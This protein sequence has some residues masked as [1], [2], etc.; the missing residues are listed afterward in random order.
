MADNDHGHDGGALSYELII[1]PNS[2]KHV[3]P[4][5]ALLSN[6]HNGASSSSRRFSSKEL[7]KGRLIAFCNLN[8]DGGGGDGQSQQ[9]W[10]S[11]SSMRKERNGGELT[12]PSTGTGDSSSMLTWTLSQKEL[13]QRK[14]KHPKIKVS[15]FLVIN[16]ASS[17]SSSNVNGIDSV[18]FENDDNDEHHA[19]KSDEVQT[20]ATSTNFW[21]RRTMEHVGWIAMDVRDIPVVHSGEAEAGEGNLDYL[22]CLSH[23]KRSIFKVSGAALGAEVTVSSCL[24][25]Y[26]YGIGSNNS[27]EEAQHATGTPLARRQGLEQEVTI[28]NN[29][30]RNAALHQSLALGASI[31]NDTTNFSSIYD[32]QEIKPVRGGSGSIELLENG[33]NEP[34]FNDQNLNLNYEITDKAIGIIGTGN[35]NRLMVNNTGPN[36]TSMTLPTN[37]RRPLGEL[38]ASPQHQPD[39]WVVDSENITYSSFPEEGCSDPHNSSS[40]RM[41]HNGDGEN[42]IQHQRQD[43]KENEADEWHTWKANQERIWYDKLRTKEDQMIVALTTQQQ[44]KDKERDSFLKAA[45]LEYRHLEETLQQA[46]V[47]VERN[48]QEVQA[49][50]Q[51]LHHEFTHL[52]K[53]LEDKSRLIQQQAQVAVEAERLKGAVTETRAKVAEERVQQLGTELSSLR[54]VQQREETNTRTAAA[55]SAAS[56]DVLL[57]TQKE[58]LEHEQKMEQNKLFEAMKAKLAKGASEHKRHQEHAA[59][60]ERLINIERQKV[61][62]LQARNGEESK[63]QNIIT[64]DVPAM[65]DNTEQEQEEITQLREEFQALELQMSS[66]NLQVPIVD[67]HDSF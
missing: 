35:V 19:Q 1:H 17:S 61:Q 51:Q 28:S 20:T 30:T 62:A 47:D 53:E 16:N 8:H 42:I 11:L 45:A 43:E 66:T 64:T 6:K 23:F 58:Q 44:E 57:Q 31:N 14:A 37:M 24:R 59:R 33:V 29:D 3:K 25:C 55:H 49:R 12:W 21:A 15:L 60:L 67:P 32:Q 52:V 13:I 46:L 9:Q 36:R 38:K 56:F 48:K 65:F 7:D 39:R 5:S 4:F 10:S 26:G 2:A 22:G 27:P 63:L 40:R 34:L 50:E 54:I 41:E 18:A